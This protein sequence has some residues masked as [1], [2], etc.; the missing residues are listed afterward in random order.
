MRFFAVVII[1]TMLSRASASQERVRALNV[2]IF[3]VEEK[4]ENSSEA[5]LRQRKPQIGGISHEAKC[6]A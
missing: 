2:V 4:I 5:N 1:W 3:Q 6:D